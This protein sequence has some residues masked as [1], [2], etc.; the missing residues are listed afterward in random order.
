[1]IGRAP[2][3]VTLDRVSEPIGVLLAGGRGRRLA[4]AKTTATLAGRPLIAYPLAA[5]QAA[6]ADVAIVTKSGVGLPTLDGVAIWT[7]PDAP[8]HPLVGIVHALQVAAGRAVLVCPADLPFVDAATLRMLADADAD[9]APAVVASGSSSSG[10]QPLLGCYRPEAAPR[11]RA[12]AAGGTASVRDVVRGLGPR[13]VEI[14]D[15]DVLFNVNTPEDLAEA[16][17][18]L[19]GRA[20]DQPN[21][22]S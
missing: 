18:R 13:V 9:G 1:M 15:P 6:L 10:L 20:G 21:V 17:R 11:L 14:A 16:E 4:G 3:T 2:E 19:A 5:L 8:H 7:E 12:A 22:K